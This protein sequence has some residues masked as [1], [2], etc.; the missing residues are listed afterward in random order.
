MARTTNK[1]AFKMYLAPDG[2]VYEMTSREA[3][4][5]RKLVGWEMELKPGG[6]VVMSTDVNATVSKSSLVGKVKGFLRTWY[7]RLF[8]THKVDEEMSK[9]VQEKGLE[10]G[11]SIGNLFSGRYYSPDKKQTF[12]EQSM[13]ID[14]RGVDFDFVKEAGKRLGFDFGQESVLLVD[15]SNGRTLM[16]GTT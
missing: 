3:R 11:W 14:I 16:M 6:M 2:S 9:M 12:N 8:R 7:N 1:I 15:H 13:A 4:L 10:T 5:A